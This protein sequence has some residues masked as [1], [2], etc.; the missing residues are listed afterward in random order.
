MVFL[1]RWFKKES[2]KVPKRSDRGKGRD[3]PKKVE[4]WGVVGVVER[5]KRVEE[6]TL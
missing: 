5:K 1:L 3:W 2:K 4:G 6:K